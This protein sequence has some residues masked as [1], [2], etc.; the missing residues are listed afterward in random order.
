[1]A[2]IYFNSYRFD[3][4]LVAAYIIMATQAE[5]L[6]HECYALLGEA[7]CE[8]QQFLAIYN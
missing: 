6:T 3:F 1:M 5:E 4:G 2:Q 8:N 7:H